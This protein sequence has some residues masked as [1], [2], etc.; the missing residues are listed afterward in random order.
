MFCLFMSLCPV[1]DSEIEYQVCLWENSTCMIWQALD[2]K[3]LNLIGQGHR[4]KQSKSLL[5][6]INYTAQSNTVIQLPCGQSDIMCVPA[7]VA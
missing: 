4:L 3:S 6:W 5:I 7:C 1:L 2:V